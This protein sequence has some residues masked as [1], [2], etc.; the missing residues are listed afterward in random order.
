MPQMLL[1][2]FL[3]FLA[4]TASA[5]YTASG[6]DYCYDPSWTVSTLS[7]A[8]PTTSKYSNGTTTAKPT[9]SYTSTAQATLTTGGPAATSPAASPTAAGVALAPELL[10]GLLAAFVAVCLRVCPSD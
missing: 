9:T 6:S 8:K 4:G 7:T 1:G 5:Q 10:L 3:L 2:L